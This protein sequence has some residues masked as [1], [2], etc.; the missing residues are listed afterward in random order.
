MN[1]LMS[2][3]ITTSIPTSQTTK[4]KSIEVGQVG[5]R[6]FATTDATNCTDRGEVL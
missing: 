3:K 5:G 6:R 2:M 1:D 4:V